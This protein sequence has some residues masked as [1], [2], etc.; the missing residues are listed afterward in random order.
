MKIKSLLVWIAVVVFVVLTS[1]CST[2][3][4]CRSPGKKRGHGPPPHAPAHG[5]R[6]KLPSGVE[7][8]FDFDCGVY[9]VVG[10]EKH[11]WLD[12]QYYRFCN[13]QWEFSMTIENGWKVVCEEKLPPGLRKKYKVKHT[14]NKHP[15]RGLAL[16]KNK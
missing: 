5:Y 13:G 6:R 14:S 3:V 4:S 11:F 10:L 7:V 12:G 8:V 2:T 16:G 15:R 1:S 9:V